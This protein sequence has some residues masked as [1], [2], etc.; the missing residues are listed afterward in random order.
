[1]ELEGGGSVE[2][3]PGVVELPP[4]PDKAAMREKATIEIVVRT[5]ILS[6]NGGARCLPRKPYRKVKTAGDSAVP[7]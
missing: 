4:H 2:G 3:A 5:S 1:M 6:K 7:Q